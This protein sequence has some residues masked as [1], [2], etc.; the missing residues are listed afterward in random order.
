MSNQTKTLLRIDASARRENSISRQLGDRL[1]NAI[2]TGSPDPRITK[3]DVAEGLPLVNEA[4]IVANFTPDEDRT[5]EHHKTLSLSDALVEELKA[6]DTII[7]TTPI[8]NFGVPATLKAWIDMIARVGLTFRY[9]E[10]GP[11]GLLENKRAYI[12]IASGGTPIG[13]DIDYASGYLRHIMGF[14]GIT[15]V[16]IIAADQIMKNEDN[17]LRARAEIDALAVA[18]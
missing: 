13:S 11:V 14:I 7:F 10:N 15:D 2:S 8:Y 9:T 17:A 6:A 16:T 3:R 1:E 4:W 5:A 12:V 18:A